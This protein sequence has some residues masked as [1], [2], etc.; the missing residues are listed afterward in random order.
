MGQSNIHNSEASLEMEE[1]SGCERTEQG[2][3]NDSF[4]DEWN[5]SSE[6]FDKERRLDNNQRSQVGISPTNNISNARTIP[7][8]RCNVECLLIQSNAV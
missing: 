3:P 1:N 4:Q 7:S 6:R 5:R 2:N 8:I